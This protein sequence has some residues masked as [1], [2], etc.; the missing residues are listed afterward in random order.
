MAP[1]TVLLVGLRG[2]VHHLVAHIAGD[3]VSRWWLGEPVHL[4]NILPGAASQP[5]VTHHPL[6]RGSFQPWQSGVGVVV[7]A[8]AP[9]TNQ[10][11]SRH[12]TVR[13]AHMLPAPWPK[14]KFELVVF[15]VFLQ[16]AEAASPLP[17]LATV[18]HIAL[19][20]L[21]PKVYENNCREPKYE[22]E[23][24]GKTSR[25]AGLTQGPG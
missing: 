21:K 3:E 18:V 25:W 20:S 16:F 1:P 13:L 22:R 4:H 17:Y 23:S 11:W 2:G 12:N 19:V 14:R 5:P 24:G 10:R 15:K 6:P 7:L 8:P 9:D